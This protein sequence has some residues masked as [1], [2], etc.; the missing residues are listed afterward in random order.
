MTIEQTVCEMMDPISKIHIDTGRKLG[1]FWLMSMPHY[2]IINGIRRDHLFG[3]LLHAV[4]LLQ[5]L[6]LVSVNS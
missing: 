4:L 5:R 3:E 2:H 6:T 1:E